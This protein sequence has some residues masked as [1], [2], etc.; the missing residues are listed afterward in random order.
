MSDAG[1]AEVFAQYGG[2]D[3]FVFSNNAWYTTD[4]IRGYWQRV[5]NVLCGDRRDPDGI[6]K[7]GGTASADPRVEP[8][9]MDTRS[10]VTGT[11]DDSAADQGTA[12]DGAQDSKPPRDG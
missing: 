5:D 3:A 8:T 10:G 6:H 12:E 4:S 11:Q 9:G 2:R 1:F 7:E